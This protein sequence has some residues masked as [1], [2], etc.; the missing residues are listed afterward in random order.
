MS[1]L[2][3]NGRQK[4]F[5]DL[6]AAG[7]TPATAYQKAGYA[8]TSTRS[9]ASCATKLLNNAS[10]SKY[11]NE[12]RDEAKKHVGITV[13]EVVEILTV[14]VRDQSHAGQLK[15]C[16]MV[17]RIL[18]GYERDNR[19]RVPDLAAMKPEEVRALPTEQLRQ[20]AGGGG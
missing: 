8:T 6:V 15:A 3:P 13:A 5:A 16:D 17:L 1:V 9:A 4:K 20:I 18:G 2:K 11:I 10:V 12:I 14:I 7:E 19:Q